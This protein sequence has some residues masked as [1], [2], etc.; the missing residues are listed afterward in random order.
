MS[1][2]I[3]W[4]RDTALTMRLFN[5]ALQRGLTTPPPDVADINFAQGMREGMVIATANC[6][7]IMV[8]VLNGEEYPA[9]TSMQ[10]AAD[11]AA[12]WIESAEATGFTVDPDDGRLKDADN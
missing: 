11:M 8:G 3:E 12:L 10:E 6:I 2:D 7:N 1:T 4:T 5:Q 9:V